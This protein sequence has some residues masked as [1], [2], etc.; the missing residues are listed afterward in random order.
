MRLSLVAALAAVVVPVAGCGDNLKVVE[1]V[2]AARVDA[3][4]ID[5]TEIDAQPIDAA[6]DAVPPDASCPA[7]APGQ[8]GGPCTSDAQ[9]DSAVGAADGFCLRG[10]QGAIIWPAQGYCVN[11]TDAIGAPPCTSDAQ[12]GTG[13]LCATINDPLGAYNACLPACGTDPCVCPDGQACATSFFNAPLANGDRACLPGNPT[14]VDGAA[15]TEFAQCAVDS[16]CLNEPFEYPGGQCS[17]VS[18]TIGNDAT[19]A[20]GH[21]VNLADITSGFNTGTTCVDTCT[22]DGDCRQADG[23]KCVTGPGAV[24]RYC[25]HPQ[26]GD[27][28]VIDTDCGD[29][30]LWACT[31]ALPGG[32]CTVRQPCPT[33]GNSQGCPAFGSA[34]WDGATPAA[35]NLCVDRCG[36]PIDT[37]GG[38]RTGLV[39]RDIDPRMGATQVTLGCVP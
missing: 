30:V 24:G 1:L 35:T 36:G 15:C 31:G 20:G 32:A 13:N 4:M 33:P 21:C 16:Q 18:C 25:R 28:C 8:V 6:I 9:C 34:C 2:D 38:C 3:P 22:T 27:P 7:R 5:A 26:A 37:Q 10:D 11:R 17:R 29:P 14:A 23:F 19:C 12:C 39:C